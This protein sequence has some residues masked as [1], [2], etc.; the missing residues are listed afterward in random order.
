M[1]KAFLK[2]AGGSAQ[3]SASAALAAGVSIVGGGGLQGRVQCSRFPDGE[4]QRE[5]S[6]LTTSW[7]ES[8]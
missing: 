7:S 5:N 1:V 4:H 6:L 2:A 3:H 8:T